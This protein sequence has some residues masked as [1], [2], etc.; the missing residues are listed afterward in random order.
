M[1]RPAHL[2]PGSALLLGLL[3]VAAARGQYPGRVTQ[4]PPAAQPELR[5]VAVYEYTGDLAKPTRSRLVPVTVWDGTEFQ[6]GG[7]YLAAPA[8]LAVESGTLY[9]LEQNGNPK[10]LI[11]LREA[12]RIA[13][14]WIGLGAY[15]PE[16]PPQLARLRPVKPI[17]IRD[18]DSDLPHFAY[19]PPSD[20]G[21]KA[22]GGNQSKNGS[23]PV[24]PDRP[25]LHRHTSDSAAPAASAAPATDDDRPT[26]H[27]HLSNAAPPDSAGPDPDRPHL[28]RGRPAAQLALDKMDALTGLPEDMDQMVAVSDASSAT[29]HAYTWTWASPGEQTAARTAMEDLARKLLAPPSHPNP[30]P[31]AKPAAPTGNQT[32]AHRRSARKPVVTPASLTDEDF[33]AFE[34]SWGSGAVYVLSARTALAAEQTEYVTLIAKPDLNGGLITLFQQVT[35]STLLDYQPRMRLVDAVDPTGNHRADLLFELRT[36]N[37]RQFAL[38]SVS[39]SQA[40]P[41][42]TTAPSQ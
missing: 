8:P 41:V 25:T 37:D 4:P 7:L 26:L 23:A 27:R 14:G 16:P 35:P 2:R 21:G 11:H 34:L 3:G 38:Y 36:R 31:P 15:E 12:E 29:G 42:F 33:R 10:G 24:D 22:S 9:E 1:S 5:A 28:R 32:T 19:R 30:S 18:D 17:Q 39:A 20:S 40:E 13:S 6:P